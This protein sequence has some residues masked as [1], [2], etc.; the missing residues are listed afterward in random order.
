MAF[1]NVD[2][3]CVAPISIAKGVLT[4]SH[5]SKGSFRVT[6]TNLKPDAGIVGFSNSLLSESISFDPMSFQHVISLIRVSREMSQSWSGVIQPLENYDFWAIGLNC[7]SLNTADFHCGQR[8]S[9]GF[10]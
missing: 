4:I 8:L 1:K 6:V 2:T 10:Q 5:E 9:E 7:C 3:Y